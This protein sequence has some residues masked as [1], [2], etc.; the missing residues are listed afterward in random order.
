[1]A[2]HKKYNKSVLGRGLDDIGNGR[3]LDA[4]ID[5][6]EVRTQGS[7]NLNE[8]AISQIVPNPNQPRREFD[9][10]ALM[11]LANSIKEIGIIQPITLRQ[12]PDGQYQII[13]GERRWR[14]SQLAGLTTIPAYIKTVKDETVMEMAL[15]ENIQREDL[16]AIEIALAYEH[17]AEAT[18]MTQE[19]ISERVGKSRAAVPN[20]MRLLKLPAQVQ[21]A[22]KDKVIDMGRARALLSIDSPS[23]Q[24]R[25]FKEIERN[26][27]SV[28]K[29]EELVKQLKSGEDVLV[30]G[31]KI[32]NKNKLPDE[33][34]LLRD[35]LSEF[36]QAKVMMTCSPKG[37]G[38]ISISFDNEEQLER[39]MH[40]LDGTRH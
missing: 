6:G 24:I 20:Y 9:E 31:K 14:A 27:Y 40:A 17:L 3:G 8:I 5:T 18:G 23:T 29:V 15:V 16:N 36:F 2:V 26:G 34:N 10:T 21:M 22:L 35:R 30:N 32:V 37:K 38:K 13:A 4:L 25:L 19:K 39:I 28:R 12:T 11:E 1:M 7:S 33:F